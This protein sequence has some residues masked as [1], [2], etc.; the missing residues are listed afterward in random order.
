[1]EK[2]LLG[3]TGFMVSRITYG[4]IISMRESQCDSDRYVSY[5]VDRG[6]NYF[7]VA[8]SYEDAQDRL[9]P[10]LKPY[11]QNV[12]LACKTE[13]RD[14]AG[15]KEELL[16]SLELL[17]TDY[18]D[19][20]QLHAMTTEEDLV[21]VFDKDGA[22]ETLVWAKKEGLIRNIGITTHSE[23]C[24]LGALD[25]FPFD[26]VLFPMNWALGINTGWGDR[27]SERVKKE[28]IGLLAMKTLI[29]R[30]WRDGEKRVYPKSWCKPVFD[31][32]ALGIA[33]MKYGLF[34]GAA[35]LIPP[36][37]F[38]R[39]SFMVDHIDQALSAPLADCEWELLRSEAEKVKEEMIF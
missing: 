17:Q 33:G 9:G 32:E 30:R 7:D 27:I 14:A 8:P 38:D 37:N 31:N 12:Y 39:F 6:I 29:H 10:S 16:R 3:K 34:K 5:A 26:T 25:Q 28:N 2:A 21:R 4:G 20:Y 1:M 18:F 23:D 22:M 35:T 13:R 15:A 19:V 36:G 24:V 11:R